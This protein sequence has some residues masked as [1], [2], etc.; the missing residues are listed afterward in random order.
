MFKKMLAIMGMLLMLA[1]LVSCSD[2]DVDFELTTEPVVDIVWSNISL[3]DKLPAPKF[4]QAKVYKNSPEGIY[5]A[6]CNTSSDDY[7]EYVEQCK[8]LGYI[9]D[10]VIA[11]TSFEAYNTDGYR[12]KIVYHADDMEMDVTLDIPIVFGAYVLPEYANNLPR[13]ASDLGSFGWQFD[14]SFYLHIGNTTYQ[15]YQEYVSACKSSGFVVNPYEYEKS[16]FADNASGYS[17]TLK[18]EGFNTMSIT[19]EAPDSIE[20]SDKDNSS[21]G[22]NETSKDTIDSDDKNTETSGTIEDNI[23][24]ISNNSDFK[25]LLELKDPSDSFIGTFASK[26]EG[27]TVEF[28]GCILAMNNH[29]DFKTRYDIL[30]GSGE[31]DENSTSG[32]AFRLTD[33]AAYSMKLDTM[34]VEEVLSVGTNIHIVAKLEKYNDFTTIYELDVV[35]VAVRD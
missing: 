29:G 17:I 4:S 28:D 25:K 15:D 12:V 30:I 5:L 2:E 14:R 31:F 34:Y 8:Q 32:P 20:P 33:V 21:T 9:I 7:T 3:G 6:L 27:Q 35:S 19:Y 18:Y 1:T 13:P 26:Y 11:N 24:T 22:T 23:I 16:Y 10:A